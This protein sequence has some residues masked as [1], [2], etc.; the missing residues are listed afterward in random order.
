M[1]SA[2]KISHPHPFRRSKIFV[3]R[4]YIGKHNV[5]YMD[6]GE[7]KTSQFQ[8]SVKACSPCEY[9]QRRNETFDASFRRTLFGLSACSPNGDVRWLKET[10]DSFLDVR[11]KCVS[12]R[13][14]GRA[15][16]RKSPLGEHAFSPKIKFFEETRH[17]SFVRLR[18]SARVMFF[19]SSIP[20]KHSNERGRTSHATLTPKPHARLTFWVCRRFSHAHRR[21][22][23]HV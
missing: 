10:F 13:F 17:R 18:F 23:R 21:V 20:H 7:Q 9:F 1:K 15:T 2:Y 4:A 6:C 11:F 8:A 22:A 16:V 19:A 5:S 14:W 12:T 3:W